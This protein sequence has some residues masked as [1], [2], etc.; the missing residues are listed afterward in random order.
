M[1]KRKDRKLLTRTIKDSHA[2]FHDAAGRAPGRTAEHDIAAA[3]I[4]KQYTF[5]LTAADAGQLEDAEKLLMV[6]DRNARGF[7]LSLGGQEAE[8]PKRKLPGE[9]SSAARQPASNPPPQKPTEDRP[10]Y[11]A[12]GYLDLADGGRVFVPEGYY[13][14]PFWKQGLDPKTAAAAGV[15]VAAGGIITGLIV[16]EGLK[17]EPGPPEASEFAGSEWTS[18]ELGDG[19]G[20]DAGD[21]DVDWGGI[22]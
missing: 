14:E 22:L 8:S 17:P 4:E 11:F 7:L 2:A 16:A 9:R 18:S 6:A 19:S 10:Y 12:G 15:G 13:P 5:A 3:D 1:A 21:W 20:D